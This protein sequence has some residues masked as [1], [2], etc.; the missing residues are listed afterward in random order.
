MLRRTGWIA[1]R[2]QHAE[3]DRGQLR[4]TLYLTALEKF[5]V[6]FRLFRR[7]GQCELLRESSMVKL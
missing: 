2:L 6:Y 5:F 1:E 3:L 7:V 4:S